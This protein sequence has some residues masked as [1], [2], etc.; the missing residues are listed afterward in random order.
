VILSAMSPLQHFRNLTYGILDLRD[1]IY[2]GFFFFYF[3]FLSLRSIETRNWK[4]FE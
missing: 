4:H 2:F 3:L 1:I